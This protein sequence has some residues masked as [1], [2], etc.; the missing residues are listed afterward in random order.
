MVINRYLLLSY[1]NR[2]QTWSSTSSSTLITI[3]QQRYTIVSHHK[4]NNNYIPSKFFVIFFCLRPPSD[5]PR[6]PYR[7]LD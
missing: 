3:N 4:G 7:T 5:L 1:I 6:L 2:P